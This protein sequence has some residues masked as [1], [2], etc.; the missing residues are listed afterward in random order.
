MKVLI[1]SQNN[2]SHDNEFP[3]EPVTLSEE[4]FDEAIN[5]FPLIVV[6]I[7]AEWCPPCK[8]L[9]P[10]IEDLAGELAGE[11]V[12]GKLNVDDNQGIAQRLGISSVPTLI[13]MKDAEEADRLIGLTPKESLKEKILD[14]K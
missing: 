4:N 2:E 7:W 11:V 13:I 12:F 10:I 3:S 6:D 8:A 14:Y 5:K 9:T 1:I